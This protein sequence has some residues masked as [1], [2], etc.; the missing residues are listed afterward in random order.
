[1]ANQVTVCHGQSDL[2]ITP[3]PLFISPELAASARK[4][5]S[6][7]CL[8]CLTLHFFVGTLLISC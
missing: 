7:I 3:A 4:T 8:I 6:Q 2:C 5:V 1:M